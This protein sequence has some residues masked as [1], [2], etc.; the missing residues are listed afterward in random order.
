MIIIIH[1][2]SIDRKLYEI[3]FSICR[4]EFFACAAQNLELALMLSLNYHEILIENDKKSAHTIRINTRVFKINGL[5]IYISFCLCVYFCYEF[6][7]IFYRGYQ[8]AFSSIII[9]FFPIRSD[10]P[11]TLFPV[12]FFN[13]ILINIPARDRSALN[14]INNSKQHLNTATA[15]ACVRHYEIH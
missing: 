3:Y 11:P 2:D 6:T 4:N 12:F 10:K 13:P 1:N 15:N 14:G 9:G 5:F 8:K 7:L